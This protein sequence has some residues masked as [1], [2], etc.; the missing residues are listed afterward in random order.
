MSPTA[1]G[2]TQTAM[3]TEAPL[4][5]SYEEFLD[6]LDEDK[7]AEWVNGEVVMHSPVSR[8]HSSVNVF[9]TGIVTAFVEENDLGEM[10]AKPFLMKT[11]PDLP[12]RMPDILFVAKENL[13]RLKDNLLDGPA[14][15]VVEITSPESRSPYRSEKLYEYEQGGVREYWMIDLGRQTAEFYQRDAGAFRLVLPDENGIYQSLVLAGLYMRVEWLWEMP[16]ILS[17]LREWGLV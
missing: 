15:L 9:L 1:A 16:S 4:R 2:P 17:V 5:L 11:G 7:F 3:L 12:A 14:D 13:S 10:Y 8:R 6:W